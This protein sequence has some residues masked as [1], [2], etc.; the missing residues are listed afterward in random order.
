MIENIDY[1]R[2]IQCLSRDEETALVGSWACYPLP[3]CGAQTDTSFYHLYANVWMPRG[4]DET[5]SL[6]E[7]RQHVVNNVGV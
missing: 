5:I 1:A 2:Q 3:A 7:Y 4:S 6:V